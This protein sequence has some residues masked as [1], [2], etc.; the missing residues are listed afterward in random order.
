MSNKRKIADHNIVDIICRDIKEM[1]ADSLE[2]LIEHIY[3]VKATY[4]PE[5]ELVEIEI[6]TTQINGSIESTFGVTNIKLFESE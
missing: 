3:P 1:D 5:T 2:E 6:D 4:D